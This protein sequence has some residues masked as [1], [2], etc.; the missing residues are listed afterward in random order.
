MLNDK[1]NKLYNTIMEESKVSK[2]HLIKEDW[3][4]EKEKYDRYMDR[5]EKVLI[6]L[7][8]AND[9][10]KV[11][12]AMIAAC[13]KKGVEKS[14]FYKWE[15]AMCTAQFDCLDNVDWWK[16]N[17]FTVSPEDEKEINWYGWITQK[18]IDHQRLADD[19]E[20]QDWTRE[21]LEQGRAGEFLNYVD[22]LADSDS[23]SLEA[24]RVER[25]TTY[26]TPMYDDAAETDSLHESKKVDTKKKVIKESSW[27][28]IKR[29]HLIKENS[30]KKINWEDEDEWVINTIVDCINSND[31]KQV[32]EEWNDYDMAADLQDDLTKKRIFTKDKAEEY[33]RKTVISWIKKAEEKLE[34]KK[35]K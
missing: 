27:G 16:Q 24:D 1:F 20:G 14:K 29:K 17:G 33:I 6:G 10:S 7:I 18:L 11:S 31:P 25:A 22:Q 5:H 19:W 3:D 15:N 9:P 35:R 8:Q 12:Q 4:V 2:K 28:Q 13:K 34:K 26:D 32:A 30:N 21:I 23:E